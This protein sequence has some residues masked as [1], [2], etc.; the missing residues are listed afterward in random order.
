MLVVGGD[1]ICNPISSLKLHSCTS[2]GEDG[3]ASDIRR[4]LD[5]VTAAAE[6]GGGGEMG[7]GALKEEVDEAGNPLDCGFGFGSGVVI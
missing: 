4:C 5:A 6:A 7:K 1:W 3:D 2:L